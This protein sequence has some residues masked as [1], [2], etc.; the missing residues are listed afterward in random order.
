MKCQTAFNEHDLSD[1][2]I[3]KEIKQFKI[4]IDIF[5]NWNIVYGHKKRKCVCRKITTRQERYIVHRVSPGDISLK[6]LAKE[7]N[8]S[9]T[10]ST[11]SRMLKHAKNFSYFK[12]FAVHVENYPQAK[13]R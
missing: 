2:Q 7:G 11:L 13:E 5:L 8:M 12:K 1:R 3:T 10:K 9:V 4:I 6:L